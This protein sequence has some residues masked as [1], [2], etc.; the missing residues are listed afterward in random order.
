MNI[1]SAWLSKINW[2]AAVSALLTLLISLGL[3]ITAEQKVQIMTLIGAAA[4]V[5][6][7]IFRTFF[8]ST[9][10][11]ASAAKLR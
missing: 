5:L 6:I 10:T 9:I 7:I 8:T 11:P 1:Q 3:P 4:P 2:T